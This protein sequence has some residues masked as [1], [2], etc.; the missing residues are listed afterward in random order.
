MKEKPFD[1]DRAISTW[2]RAF[3]KHRAF[4]EGAVQEMEVHLRDHIEDMMSEGLSVRKAFEEATS[5]FGD[6]PHMAEEE[7]WNHKRKQ[8]LKNLI[9]VRLLNNYF[10]TS[11]RTL[12]KN[13]VTSFIN[14]FGLALT[15]G[16]SLMVY[17]FFDYDQ[18]LDAF[19]EHKNEVYLATSYVNREGE[20]EQYGIS[21][22][23]LGAM[24][25]QDFA[26]IE[27]VC[28]IK[29]GPVVMKDG[30]KVF[31]EQVRYVDPEFLSMFTFPL[32]WG[33]SN[34]L[35]E[36]DAIIL[37]ADMSVKYF[38]DENPVGQTIQMIV[39]EGKSKTLKV[40]GVAEQFPKAHIIAFDFLV[41]FNNLEF[42]APD[43]QI[44]DWRE[45][46]DATLIKVNDPEDLKQ[47]AEG[48]SKYLSLQNEVQT[49]WAITDFKLEPLATLHFRSANI[50]NGISYDYNQE[51]RLGL[52][53]IAIIMLVLACLN[54]INISIASA[55]KRLKEIG[56]RKV[57]GAGK[58]QVVI[59]FLTENIFL[60]FF[61]LIL[62]IILAIT[63]I[64]PW[65]TQLSG[66]PLEFD[67]WNLNLWLFLVAILLGT[68]FVS[69][70]YPA[71]YIARFD[72]IKIFKGS[73]RFGQKNRLTKVFLGFQLIMTCAGITCA[74][75]FTQNNGF[76]NN[77]HWGYN[78]KEALYVE[79][80]DFAAFSQLKALMLQ[81]PNVV[82]VAGS[83]DHLGKGISSAVV[84]M[85]G[86]RYEVRE[87][88]VDAHYFETMGL[89]LKAGSFFQENKISD[90][91][92]LV[93]NELFVK[94]LQLEAPVGQ[95]VKI[96]SMR[97]EVIG[98][99]KDFHFY[100][101]H[102]AIRPT[103]FRV[104][105]EDNYRYL[106][107]KSTGSSQEKAYHDLK[108]AY[109]ELFP[110]IPFL[111]GHQQEVFVEF[112]GMV[113]TAERFYKVVAAIAVLLA[114]LGLYGL[115]TLNVTGRSKE[116]SIRKALGA[117]WSHITAS[118]VR[119]YLVLASVALLIGVPISYYMAK[120]SL[121]M[122]YAY[123]MPVTYSGITIS[124]MIL[125]GVMVGVIL[126]QVKKVSQSNPVQGLKSE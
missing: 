48:M 57:V 114:S 38:G 75:I 47:V 112:F 96:D 24:M 76:Q 80:P 100:N 26:N 20:E 42:A 5:A 65:F 4:E 64:I 120:A 45:F 124:V 66:D 40:S 6:I 15:I 35:E 30:D 110:E 118:I 85:P 121:A 107:I 98:V 95:I 11:L 106:S 119:Q 33:T 27:Q 72:V 52:P 99:V 87:L 13:P 59:Q 53:I 71:F 81:S 23:P 43:Y 69:G 8:T 125:I 44:T 63:I 90:K 32:R 39:S 55:A 67:P 73:V 21:P 46:V 7:Y 61:A 86:N 36:P 101:F 91:Q 109:G 10:K 37:S 50:L 92:S 104:V 1:L 41:N 88:A 108:A 12:V 115:V 62:G 58:T 126:T 103:I 54:Y 93:V 2:L 22:A 89:E 17:V 82:D 14:I 123:P 31:H 9:H 29:D 68:G 97:Y 49:D 60:T 3:R 84:H 122:L 117:E 83:G 70:I 25:K 77:R 94:N 79:I 105:K 78:Q 113:N 111:G 51:A 56:L 16:I 74:V 116:F 18:K 19:H 28:R 102:A 34:S